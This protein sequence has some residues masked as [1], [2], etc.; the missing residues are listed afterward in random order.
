MKTTFFIIISLLCI[1][2]LSARENPFEPTDTYKEKQIEYLKQLELEEQEEKKLQEQMQM[3]EQA[4]IQR[5]K[6]LEDLELLKQEELRKIESLKAQRAV[7]EKEQKQKLFQIQ[8]KQMIQKNQYNVLPFVHIEEEGDDTL[9]IYVDRKFPLI[10]QDILPKRQ[11]MLFDFKGHT[12]FYTINKKLK[13]DAF[14]GFSVGTHK[15]KGFFRVVIE[16][17]DVPKTYMEKVDTNQGKITILK[18]R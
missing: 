17:N 13:S 1:V 14:K 2:E 10:N 18:K 16:L 15:K 11:K 8:Q 3:Q 9:T 4:M 7:L 5:E 6:E 12:S